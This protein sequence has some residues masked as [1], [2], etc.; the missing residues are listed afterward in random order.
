MGNGNNSASPNLTPPVSQPASPGL[1]PWLDPNWP[2][3]LQLGV[4]C[5]TPNGLIE[6][7]WLRLGTDW[8]KKVGDVCREKTL[9]Y[10]ATHRLDYL[11]F[12]F[13]PNVVVR[14]I[15]NYD[16]FTY[17]TPALLHLGKLDAGAILSVKPALPIGNS[18]PTGV[19]VWGGYHFSRFFEISGEVTYGQTSTDPYG[20]KIDTQQVFGVT[21]FA[22]RKF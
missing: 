13:H 8:K 14:P 6:L 16:G 5:E 19:G 3:P 4:L 22:Q 20:R 21:F 12:P 11:N 17:P 2:K 7:T 18:S 9:D 10:L 1:P 15:I